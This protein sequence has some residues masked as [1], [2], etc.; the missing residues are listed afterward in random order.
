MLLT[1]RATEQLSDRI[2]LAYLRRRPEWRQSG[3]DPRL[4]TAAA[5][6]LLEV[7]RR[8]SWV[9]LDPELFVACQPDSQGA[10]DPW[11]ELTRAVSGRRYLCRLRKIVRGLRRELRGEIRRVE[12]AVARGE[13]PEVAVCGAPKKSLSPLG[14][15]LAACRLG[16][17]DHADRF[18]AEARDQH[19][20][21][22]LYRQAS[23][24]LAP[25]DPYPVLPL[26]AN[27]IRPVDSH[28][29]SLN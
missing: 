3:L 5:A 8:E 21:C 20:A 1:P 23:L 4:W 10:S 25:G 11:S 22:P 7:H 28:A 13:S 16:I 2:E 17:P 12:A 29:Y 26:F 19:F 15:Y 14:R 27:S 6:I 18:L 9:P 24:G